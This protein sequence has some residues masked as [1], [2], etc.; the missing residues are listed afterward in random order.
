MHFT[1]SLVF[2]CIPNRNSCWCVSNFHI[3]KIAQASRMFACLSTPAEMSL[4]EL[5]KFLFSR[6]VIELSLTIQIPL[7]ESHQCQ[8][9]TKYHRYHTW[10]VNRQSRINELLFL[11][12]PSLHV[13]NVFIPLLHS[14]V[15][16]GELSCTWKGDHSL[17]HYKLLIEN[18]V[19]RKGKWQRSW[20]AHVLFRQDSL[21]YEWQHC[22]LSRGWLIQPSQPLQ[23]WYTMFSLAS[24]NAN[25]MLMI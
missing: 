8:N 1:I 5:I 11:I 13:G 21:P 2:L 19:R 18:L 9:L 6:P 10:N 17:G 25:R 24:W 20:Q 23:L 14:F 22:R 16:L 3:I 4:D 7:Q 15:L 12:P